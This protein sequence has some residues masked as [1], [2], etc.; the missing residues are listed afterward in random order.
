MKKSLFVLFAALSVSVGSL[1]G[2]GSSEP[3]VVEAPAVEEG[4]E[5]PAIEG[6]SDDEYTAAMDAEG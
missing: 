4:G 3:Q 6:M 5:E 2:C 1:S